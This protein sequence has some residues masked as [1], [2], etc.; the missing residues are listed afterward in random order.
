MNTS[1]IYRRWR[2]RNFWNHLNY[3]RIGMVIARLYAEETLHR[4]K[5]DVIVKIRYLAC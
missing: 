1:K 5:Y 4:V 2:L 3:D